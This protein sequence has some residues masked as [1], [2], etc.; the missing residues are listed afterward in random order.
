MGIADSDRDLTVGVVT[1]NRP[2]SLARCLASLAPLQD[3]LREVIVVD[4]TSDLP[5]ADVLARAPAS[6]ANRLRLIR[7][8]AREGYIVGRNTIMRLATTEYVLL[9]D[10]DAYLLGAS[11][12]KE[13]LAL[14]EQDAEVA[15]IGFAQAEADGRP[16]P[17][18]MQPAPVSY[19]CR[20]AS[21]IGF[22]HLLRRRTFHEV[23]GYREALHFYGEEKGLCA[24]FLSAGYQVVY[25]PDVLVA[26]VPDPAGRSTS[27]Y[28]RYVVRNDCLFALYY[29]PWLATCVNLPVRLARYF[30]MRRVSP[31][32]DPAGFFWIVWELI[33]ALPDA[34][35][36]RTPMTWP[37]VAEWRRLRR[38]PPAWHSRSLAPASSPATR[39]TVGIT[40]RNRL[41]SLAK[42]LCS[43]GLIRELLASIIV[44]DDASEIPV[45]QI[46]GLPSDL[47]DTLTIR[48][49]PKVLGNIAGRNEIMRAATTEYVLLCDDDAYLLDGDI[50]RRG[51]SL[52]ERDRAVA[53][54]G[55]AMAAP[56]GAPWPKHMQASPASHP[57]FIPSYI[58]F[59]HLIRRSAF[60]EVGGYRALYQHGEEKDCCLR[61][62]DA[63]YDIV[64]L[65]D[66]PVVHLH[67]PGGRNVKRYLR[68]VIRNDCLG[69]MFNQPL[70]MA[71]VT[72]PARLSR[73]VR[74][75]RLGKV[76]D[77]GGLF[78]IVG[79]LVAQLPTVA[80]ERRPVKWSTLRR[81]RELRRSSPV[82]DRPAARA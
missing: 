79:Q 35:R 22:A 74:M 14:M 72:V 77:P 15:A 44:I 10:D 67:D 12:L 68:Y 13:A 69:A 58:G 37:D 60:L 66:P 30:L 53:A 73:Y 2:A 63:G 52:M 81:W 47:A 3:R 27:R 17:P 21:F 78:W 59:T 7:Q 50:V 75:R 61:L 48:R 32:R 11:G 19:R 56:D 65:P 6:I 5:V 42:G 82:Y 38:Q 28:L 54:V 33:L 20:V 64:Y 71:L 29:L 70:A 45:D 57:C 1:Q 4:D 18:A 36:T 55:F 51:L 62:M 43:L 80:R 9:M 25:M 31:V 46:E 40:T 34:I 16:W 23:G 41:P 39:I 26:H 24:Q 8:T 76:H 49:Q